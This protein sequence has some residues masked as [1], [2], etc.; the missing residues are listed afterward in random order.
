MGG[1]FHKFCDFANFFETLFFKS[2]GIDV[3]HFFTT[4]VYFAFSTTLPTSF[5]WSFLP[6]NTISWLFFLNIVCEKG[7]AEIKRK[8]YIFT[9]NRC[10]SWRILFFACRV[11][12]YLPATVNRFKR[13][14]CGTTNRSKKE[15]VTIFEYIS[16]GKQ[17]SD[18]NYYQKLHHV[19]Y[20]VGKGKQYFY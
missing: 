3:L 19:E 2:F 5:T 13:N 11:R 10:W 14:P 18:K 16:L 15:I 9:F 4:Q 20:Y 1:H 17:L 8:M 7:Q 12:N 6:L